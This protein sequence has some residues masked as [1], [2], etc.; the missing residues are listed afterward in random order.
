MASSGGTATRRG[1]AAKMPALRS[2]LGLPEAG[3]LKGAMVI[4]VHRR[5]RWLAVVLGLLALKPGYGAGLQ[6]LKAEIGGDPN[7]TDGSESSIEHTE[8]RLTPA[9]ASSSG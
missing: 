4:W 5:G 1:A 8:A 3:E 7:S 9:P 2:L 6:I